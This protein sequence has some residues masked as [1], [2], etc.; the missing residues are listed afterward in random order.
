MGEIDKLL[1]NKGKDSLFSD[2]LAITLK[3]L[4]NNLWKDLSGDEILH[5]VEDYLR[6]ISDTPPYELKGGKKHFKPKV[7]VYNPME[8]SD[9][10]HLFSRD[11]TVVEIHTTNK[12][13]IFESVRNY[14]I[15]KGFRI[16]GVVH[17]T[18]HAEREERKLIRVSN[19]CKGECELFINFYIEKITEKGKIKE[20][21][22]DIP[23]ILRC[24]SYSIDDFYEM[25]EKLNHLSDSIDGLQVPYSIYNGREVCE[26]LKWIAADNFVILGVRDY[27]IRE[28]KGKKLLF[29][30]EQKG[31]GIFREKGLVE[32]IIPGFIRE[33]EDII[34]LR[35]AT[36]RFVSSDFCS[37]GDNIIYQ[38][39][40]VEF[41]SIRH[42]KWTEGEKRETVLIGRLTRGATNWRSDAIPILRRK[43]Q[44]LTENVE[45]G[46]SSFEF[47]EARAIFNYLPKQE[48]LYTTI[49]QLRETIFNIMSA[50]SDEDVTVHIRMG[51]KGRYAMV[52]VTIA[53]NDNSY[54]VRRAI[55]RH[56]TTYFNR[57]LA[58]WHHSS[59]E[60]R[61][62]L[63]YYFVS[64]GKEF[65]E[66]SSLVLEDAIREISTDWDER[67]YLALYNDM[68]SRASL[69]FNRYIGSIDKLYKDST[70]PKDA[71]PDINKL[72]D[73]FNDG[74]L[75]IGYRHQG[76][77]LAI[78]SLYSLTTVPLM[79]ILK[80]L[81]NFGLYVTGEQA[82]YF[83]DIPG[84]GSAFLYNYTIKGEPLELGRLKGLIPLFYDALVSIREGRLEDDRLNRLLTLEGMEWRAV[85]LIRTLKNY[86]LQANRVYNNA[87][88][89][90]TIIRYSYYARDL[91]GL[92]HVKFNP[93]IKSK[94][95]RRKLLLEAEERVLAHLADIQSL[96]DY[97]IL[98]SL[99]QVVGATVRTNFYI[100]P[101]KE[102]ISIK[103][104]ARE[105]AIIP[106]PRPMAEIYVHSPT[107]EGI[108]LRDGRVSRGGI[109]WSDRGDDFRTEILALMKTQKLK[110]GII[111]P[112]GAK[113]GFFVKKRPFLAKEGLYEYM[114]A[115]YSLFI[116][117]LLDLTDN[118]A[119]EKEIS[120][121]GVLSYDDFDPYLVVAADKG[122][123]LLSDRANEIS[124]NCNFWLGDAFA[125][126]GATGYDHKKIGITARGAWESI[127]REFREIGID[128]QK[129][130]V[131]V[132]GIGD[133]S[134]DVFGNGMLLSDKLKLVGAFNHLHIFLDPHPDPQKSFRERKRL[135]GLA[136][137]SWNDYSSDLISKGGGVYLRSAKSIP[138]SLQMA[139]YLGTEKREVTGEEMVRLLL[140]A[141]VD[142]LY[143]GGIGTYIKSTDENDMEAGDKANDRVRVNGR[144]VR[145]RIIGE[146]GNLGMTQ[147]GRLEYSRG[148]GRCYT[149][150]LDNSGG[151]NI[152]DHEV[153]LKIMLTYLLEKG[154][155]RSLEERNRI[156]LEMTDQVS[157]KVL[158]N[159]YLQSAACSI[160]SLRAGKN[161]EAFIFVIDEMERTTGLDRSEEFIPSSQDMKETLQ[162][163]D[164]VFSRPMIASL[165]GYQK[166]VYYRTI[167]ESNLLDSFYVQKYLVD[168]FPERMRREFEPFLAEHR[169]K[170]E[171]ISTAIV[172]R[173]INRAG[174]SLF[175]LIASYTGKTI[176]EIAMAYIIVE[177]LLQA[178]KFREEVHA[179]DNMVSADLQYEY[180]IAMEEII[181]YAIRWFLVHQ[182]EERISFDFILQYS[183][184]VKS[185]HHG[186]WE[187]IGEICRH[188]K[189]AL[190][191]DNVKRDVEMKVPDALAK[192]YAVLP[193]MK[194]VMDIIRIKEEHHANFNETA[195]LYLKVSDYFNIDWLIDSVNAIKASDRWGSESVFNMRHELKDCQDGIV[196]T[197]LNFKRK[198]EDLQ[199]AFEHYLQE[200]VDDVEDYNRSVEELKGE[201][202][203]GIISLSVIIRKLSRFMVRS[204][205]ER[206]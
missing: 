28:E 69:L 93:G 42:D 100:K 56:L 113:G 183:Q 55:E 54:S 76:E 150:A 30:D 176:P 70:P 177:N 59:T 49:E 13:F 16:I 139:E 191:S 97:Q 2:F 129:E 137:S 127:K 124:K 110:N 25:K 19:G 40:P 47:R 53:R 107:F 45:E 201:G 103:V 190:L 206:G 39:S 194:D 161:S 31:L 90:E 99:F 80:E 60:A 32:K 27:E 87:S 154:E 61:A 66:V 200:K 163:G 121:K 112:E 34:L 82:C 202:K 203:V 7:R 119:E 205:D 131:T 23:A 189:V 51:D 94:K 152:S 149:D 155:I 184:A 104:S 5:A 65:E 9:H 68:E 126:G 91:F 77:G 169:L 17:P 26:F 125:S 83:K 172:N 29:T 111:V 135:F 101:E 178:E 144:R 114:K 156:L 22:H 142:L 192:S 122:T 85:D 158:K 132:V 186:L 3:T 148:G 20:I 133:M 33:V 117:G 175:P 199:E 52:M 128:V 153:N 187:C 134:G 120:P 136:R 38:L 67:F 73:L 167:L 84:N 74:S 12:P 35:A 193:F 141:G 46:A 1:S 198:S 18:F 168:Y 145:A 89:I 171:I 159:N 71:L 6:V 123:A 138:V 162:K 147:R 81:E 108:H 48:I 197:V 166:M 50:Q 88:V 78:L 58:L 151:V 182:P 8:D 157:Q 10:K 106:S 75:Q 11:T 164:N 118:Y 63:F 79:Q 196:L 72:E 116:N 146:G 181:A 41:F 62:L 195:R 21:C 185:F 109:R 14:F 160:D 57:P 173:I 4:P 188:E 170:R 36:D 102:Y 24:L 165:I 174:I 64:P 105:L 86:L 43:S 44:L 140:T 15:K 179:L 115:Q 98:N 96:G 37:S 204:E 143:N 130:S 92:F 180:L 95:E